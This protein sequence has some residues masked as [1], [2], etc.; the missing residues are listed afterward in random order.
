MAAIVRA[1]Q[2]SVGF[3]LLSYTSVLIGG[4]S[5]RT[6]FKSPNIARPYLKKIK[7]F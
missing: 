1:G 5:G 3:W 4:V 2:T 6:I 7:F